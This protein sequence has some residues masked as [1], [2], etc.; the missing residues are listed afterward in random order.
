M[1]AA[2]QQPER[3]Q[4]LRVSPAMGNPVS[5]Q[6]NWENV[7]ITS[8]HVRDVS[9]GGLAFAIP[10]DITRPAPGAI[11]NEINLEIPSQGQ[12]KVQGKVARYDVSSNRSTSIC[13]I[14][15]IRVPT[16]AERRLFQYINQRQREIRWFT[17]ES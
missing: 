13:A 12:I 16:G 3:R 10:S 5:V 2:S 15:F 4:Y 9:L 1:G 7:T 17:K 14:Q 11:I 8:K 6:F